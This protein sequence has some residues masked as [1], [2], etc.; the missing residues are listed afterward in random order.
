MRERLFRKK[1]ARHP[2]ITRVGYTRR[3]VLLYIF[4]LKGEL[5]NSEWPNTQNEFDIGSKSDGTWSYKLTNKW[6]KLLPNQVNVNLRLRSSKL[7]KNY[8]TWIQNRISV[9]NVFMHWGWQQNDYGCC[10]LKLTF[11]LTYNVAKMG[12]NLFQKIKLSYEEC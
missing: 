1:C 12:R 2:L 3:F 5:E 9:L 8:C 10:I 6:N 11:W 7:A 4:I